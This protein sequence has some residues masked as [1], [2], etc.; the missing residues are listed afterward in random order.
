MTITWLH[1][2]RIEF[3]I[4]TKVDQNTNTTSLLQGRP[5]PSHAGVYQCVFND[6]AG[7]ILSANISLGK[8]PTPI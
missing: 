4:T 6:N 1:D 7:C 2:D 3:I 5:R 8:L